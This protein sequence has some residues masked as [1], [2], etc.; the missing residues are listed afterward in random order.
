M[1]IRGKPN[2]DD[3]LDGGA[4]AA[5]SP[6]KAPATARKG[7]AAPAATEPA[8]RISKLFQ[9]PE[10]MMADLEQRCID[11]RRQLGRR[12]TQTEIVERALETY[13]YG[14]K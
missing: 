3:F 14:N 8:K 13:L 9:L 6:A 2:V 11:E 10:A 1:T 4:E 12:V 7:K 5:K